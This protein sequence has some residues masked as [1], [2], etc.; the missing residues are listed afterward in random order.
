[1]T[2]IEL[3]KER[4]DKEIEKQGSLRKAAKELGV[5]S[6]ILSK[7]RNGKYIPKRKSILKW[8]PELADADVDVEDKAS[9]IIVNRTEIVLKCD[10]IEEIKQKLDA[11]G[12][13]MIV[14]IVKKR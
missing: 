2:L 14:N 4:I 1:M 6:S 12:Y 3:A 13:E 11:L 5:D 10:Q 9:V 7:I 8:F